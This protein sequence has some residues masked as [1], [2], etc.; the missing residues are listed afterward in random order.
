[1]KSNHKLGFTLI[2]LL[3]VIAIIAILAAILFPVFASAK[4]AAK[5]AGAISDIKQLILASKLYQ[6]SYD[7]FFAPK[8]RIGYDVSRGGDDP[9]VAMSFD[10]LIQ[11][12]TKNYQVFVSSMDPR[13][14]YETPYGSARRSYGVASNVYR[15]V[16]VNPQFGWGAGP[17]KGAISES[18]IPQTADTI[19]IGEKRQPSVTTPNFWSHQDWYVG[20]QM[21]NSRRDDLPPGDAAAPYGEIAYRYSEGAVWAFVDGHAKWYKANGRRLTDNKIVGTRFPG[22]VEKAAQWVGNPDPFWDRGLACFDS[23]WIAADGDCPLPGQ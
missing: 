9:T 11:P 22:Y 2:E 20:V 7:D 19:A 8:L 17:W 21:N 5:K 13:T 6:D 16:Q 4:V 12:Y 18:A 10:K 3:V 15:A 14:K 1:M 23:G